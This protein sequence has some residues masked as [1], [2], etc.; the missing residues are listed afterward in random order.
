MKIKK[1]SFKEYVL[2]LFS[3]AKGNIMIVMIFKYVNKDRL[4]RLSMSSFI[5]VSIIFFQQTM[6]CHVLMRTIQISMTCHFPHLKNYG[7]I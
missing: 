3:V 6:S 7:Y 2:K 1:R 4:I 5:T